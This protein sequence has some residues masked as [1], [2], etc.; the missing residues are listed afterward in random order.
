VTAGKRRDVVELQP[1]QPYTQDRFGYRHPI[2]VASDEGPIALPE[3]SPTIAW[4]NAQIDAYAAREGIDVA[5]AKNKPERLAA[6]DAHRASTQPALP[7]G[8]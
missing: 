3:G 7:P 1:G 8:E 4:T 6:I 5:S 2:V